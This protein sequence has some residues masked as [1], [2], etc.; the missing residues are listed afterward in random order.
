MRTSHGNDARLTYRRR[1]TGRVK[2]CPFTIHF[3]AD[4]LSEE[5]ACHLVK[6]LFEVTKG[7]NAERTEVGYQDV[8]M[9]A[10]QMR[11]LLDRDR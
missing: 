8:R 11:N 4:L 10:E 5:G 6:W 1:F 2:H 3:D 9:D 7:R